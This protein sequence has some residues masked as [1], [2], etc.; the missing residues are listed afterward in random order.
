MPGCRTPPRGALVLRCMVPRSAASTRPRCER[1]P[2][3]GD[4][5]ALGCMR[6]DGFRHEFAL[7]STR[8]LCECGENLRRFG[9]ASHK[10]ASQRCLVGSPEFMGSPLR[11]AFI[12]AQQHSKRL[13]SRCD[14]PVTF[15]VGRHSSRLHLLLEEL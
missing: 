13:L 2:R 6:Q 3:G 10:P 4:G 7:V 5:M 14:D 1:P 12:Y 8:R 15:P 9:A 11:N